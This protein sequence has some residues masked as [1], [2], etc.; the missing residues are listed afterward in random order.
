M[1]QVQHAFLILGMVPS[2]A[3][4]IVCDSCQDVCT[5]KSF[6]DAAGQSRSLIAKQTVKILASTNFSLEH[7]LLPGPHHQV[8]M[9]H[10]PSPQQ[11]WANLV[12]QANSV[13]TRGQSHM[14]DSSTSVSILALGV[15]VAI[16]IGV[17]VWRL[18]SVEKRVVEDAVPV[19]VTGPSENDEVW[20]P[21]RG[22]RGSGG[23][24]SGG[25]RQE[26][27]PQPRREAEAEAAG[28]SSSAHGIAP[29]DPQYPSAAAAGQT[30]LV[31]YP[32]LPMK[33]FAE[34][35]SGASAAKRKGE[36][37]KGH[38]DPTIAGGIADRFKSMGKSVFKKS[39]AKD[40]YK[41]AR[42]GVA[43]VADTIQDAREDFQSE[44]QQASY[45]ST[46][47]VGRQ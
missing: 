32:N 15:V 43:V 28:A 8:A 16:L 13:R 24:G 46:R 11:V 29:G 21:Q 17:A 7:D 18:R 39:G 1:L 10:V 22:Q 40:V 19:K 27:W 45:Q 3:T 20:V 2:S 33:P 42:D 35:P 38:Q 47:E 12:E 31:S 36:K 44:F 41:A 37:P 26:T 9:L 6:T 23:R 4:D 25:R 5:A 30:P 34:D 14:R